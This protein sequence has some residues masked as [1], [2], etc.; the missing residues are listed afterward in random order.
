MIYADLNV[1]LVPDS[2]ELFLYGPTLVTITVS[3]WDEERNKVNIP[4][5]RFQG[6]CIKRTSIEVA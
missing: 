1:G 3:I 2:L 6:R 5:V 4:Y